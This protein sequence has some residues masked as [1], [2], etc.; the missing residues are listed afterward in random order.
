M[1]VNVAVVI[2]T[3]GR[4]LKIESIRKVLRSL[5]ALG[6]TDDVEWLQNKILLQIKWITFYET[7]CI[8]MIII[9]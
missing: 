9:R 1:N 4:N 3:L 2:S 5:A 6:M 8:C 7:P